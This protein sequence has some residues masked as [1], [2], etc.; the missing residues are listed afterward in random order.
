MATTTKQKPELEQTRSTNSIFVDGTR[1]AIPIYCGVSGSTAKAIISAL[2][3][4][5]GSGSSH[6]VTP[7]GITVQHSGETVAEREIVN[8][9]RIDLHTL[10]SLLFGSDTRGMSLDLAL[11]VQAE[12]ADTVQ[13]ITREM[14]EEAFANSLSHYE[15]YGPKED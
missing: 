3:A 14:V 12:I 4:K 8:R 9:L 10:R 15:F 5:A 2:R 1:I 11:R 13:F 6:I 7:G